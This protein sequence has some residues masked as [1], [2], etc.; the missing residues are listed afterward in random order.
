MRR[1][2]LIGAFVGLAFAVVTFDVRYLAGIGPRWEH[3]SPD[4][5]AYLAATQYYIADAWRLPVFAV[6]PMGY[7]EGGSVIYNDAVPIGALASKIGA[8]IAGV[9]VAHLGP[10]IVLCHV[11]QGAFIARLAWLA[12]NR[13]L[14]A[15]PAL[16]AIAMSS[17]IL[18]IRAE[19]I[20]LMSHFLLVWALCL[21]VRARVGRL[22]TPGV[23]VLAGL[24][25]LVNAYLFVM[26]IAV[27]SAAAISIEMRGTARDQLR[28]TTALS[29]LVILA[30]LFT[31]GFVPTPE[32]GRLASWGF[33]YFSWDPATLVVPPPGLW[34]W[35]AGM[36]RNAAGGGPYEG[37]SYLGVGA[38]G[39]LA[40]AAYVHRREIVP[41][42][43]RH[44]A[45]LAIIAVCAAFAVSS[46]IFVAT[47]HVVDLPM[48]PWMAR[49][50]ATMR[51]SGRFIWPLVY[52]LSLIP[53][54]LLMTRMPRR[55]WLVALY[56]AAMAQTLET[57]PVRQTARLY[58]R[59][60]EPDV[61]G[62]DRFASW[63]HGHTRV[64]QYPSWFCGGLGRDASVRHTAVRRETQIQ[65]LAARAG[66]P[67][68]SVYMARRI[69]DCDREA[70]E[71]Q[72]LRMDDDTLYV[73]GP[74]AV[75]RVP[76]LRDRAA[77]GACQSVGWA[78]VC[79]SRW[80]FEQPAFANAPSRLP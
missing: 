58:S 46:R 4:L 36:A 13:S 14:L 39:F 72:A 7:P 54:L 11:L 15:V 53:A 63:L 64:W 42:L 25:L 55:A 76:G 29:A 3:P 17:L 10:W 20:A 62:R 40:A 43:R 73:F 8:S 79:S 19:H 2:I 45:L 52:V 12:G 77:T 71:A 44:A 41:L 5:V 50:A 38:L 9:R 57:W 18:L 67:M 65:F 70:A 35:G 33:G 6:P 21:Y 32:G 47:W 59:S 37:E 31:A 28:R 34:P 16:V 75:A 26:V 30:L 69:K 49:A 22:S 1:Q 27:L 80:T 51:A 60:V 74:E 48:L 23:I 66:I 78:L 24:S 68:N 56:V 61:I